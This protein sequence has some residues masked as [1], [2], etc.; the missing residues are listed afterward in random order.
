MTPD[1]SPAND[2]ILV[3]QHSHGVSCDI[4]RFS[5]PP[6][7]SVPH[8]EEAVRQALRLAR[9]HGVAA[10]FTVDQTHYMRLADAAP[11]A[12]AGTAADSAAS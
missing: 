1:V 11:G 2:D 6:Q 4:S 8:F 7:F 12:P 9:G 3:S 5:G 10:W